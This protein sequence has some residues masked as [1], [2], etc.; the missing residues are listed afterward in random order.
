M[1]PLR[2][3]MIEDMQLKGLAERTQQ[4]YVAAVRG[5]AEYDN[6]SPEQMSEGELR[7]Y[8][9]YLKNEKKAAASTCGQVLSALKFLYQETL[10][11]EFP[12]LDFVKMVRF[13][14]KCQTSV[15]DR[16]YEKFEGLE[17]R[18][19][20]MIKVAEDLLMEQCRDLMQNGAKHFHFYTL[21]K[22]EIPA[23]ICK[24]L[25]LT[26]KQAKTA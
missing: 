15:P 19:D 7:T 8:L 16:L 10:K 12:I 1:T 9:L 11:Q 13:A 3:R 18:P 20:E 4:S 25:G 17:N 26:G 22:A 24:S 14:E 23:S 21:N 5:L 6:K 2:Q